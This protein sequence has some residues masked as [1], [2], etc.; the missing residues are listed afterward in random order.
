[1]LARYSISNCFKSRNW[2]TSF[3][4]L[5]TTNN[6]GPNPNQGIIDLLKRDKETEENSPV[7]NPFKLVAFS[8]A[9]KAISNVKVP[10]RSG[11]G[12]MGLPGVGP[13]I[14]AR[15][16][17][18]LS[19]HQD[20]SQ[21]PETQSE[22]IKSRALGMLQGVPGIG[23]TKAKKLVDAGCM[24][25]SDLRT[26]KFASILTKAQLARFKYLGLE[27]HKTS[28]QEAEDVLCFCR[29]S[30]DSK[31]EL[32]LVGDYRRGAVSF[33]DISLMISHPD[34]V[35][36]PLPTEPPGETVSKKRGRPSASS[37]KLNNLLHNDAVPLLQ[38]RGLV[39][40]SLSV[41]SM[42]WQGIV[43][44]PVMAESSA[45]SAE[46]IAAIKEI[47]GQYRMMHIT[48]VPQKSRGIGLLSLTG[49]SAF[50]K[51]MSD[52]AK[53][54]NLHLNNHGLWSWHSND[55]GSLEDAFD[56]SGSSSGHWRLVKSAT[57]HD[58]FEELG[59]DFIEPEK[60]S[61]LFVSGRRKR[62]STNIPD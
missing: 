57:E 8:K 22:L 11:N 50:N 28:R 17:N 5:Y 44:L 27:E 56:G 36:I 37:S 61:F 13:R 29:G 33:T 31:Y 48:I 53:Q 4:R 21:D 46:R 38:K 25:L 62:K 40:E 26:D 30:L 42:S 1:M 52:T 24:S 60:R 34:Y 2:P 59:L 12:V 35:H 32:S 9:I 15:I 14:M 55:N 49:D 3:C 16:D 47:S 41:N 10:I 20:S 51:Y 18:Y 23:L 39:V 19:S 7:K 45:S 58:V 54:L 43:R 6:I